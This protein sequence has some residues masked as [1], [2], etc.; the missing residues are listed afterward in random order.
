M[1]SEIEKFQNDLLESVKVDEQES[2]IAAGT[3]L[4]VEERGDG[5]HQFAPVHQLGEDVMGGEELKLVTGLPRLGH[6]VELA[7]EGDRR[8]VVV[9][10]QPDR[11]V[12]PDATPVRSDHLVLDRSR[13]HRTGNDG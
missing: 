4:V 9:T 11:V 7:D 12:D 2:H 10:Q 5:A 8:A 3:R 6:V 13:A 1:P